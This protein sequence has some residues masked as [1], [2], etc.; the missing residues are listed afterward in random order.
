MKD[1]LLRLAMIDGGIVLDAA[2]GR[3]EFINTIKSSF[4]TYEQVIGVDSSEKC[5]SY[6]EKLFPENNIEIYR[7]DLSSLAFDDEHFD[8]ITI[9]NSIHHLADPIAI[10]SE[11][12]RVLK[13]KGLFV[14]SEMYRDGVQSDAQKSHIIMHHWLASIDRRFGISHNETF[15]KDELIALVEKLKLKKT[16][17]YDYFLPVDN[18][19]NAQNCDNLIRNCQDALKR[20]ELAGD[21]ED[22]IREGKELIKRLG[23]VGCASA[24]RL[25]IIGHK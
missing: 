9:A 20:L 10:F 11:L 19:K 17:I 21:A 24:N 12:K 5:V 18:P 6:A 8:T 25:M 14:I 7:M 23:D 1:V 13:K 2:T 16:E 22:L 15:T 3:G 4:R